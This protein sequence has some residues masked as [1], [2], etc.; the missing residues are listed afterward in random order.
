M[1][2]ERKI[3]VALQADAQKAFLPDD[4]LDRIEANCGATEGRI[5]TTAWL[6]RRWVQVATAALV[7]LPLAGFT[8]KQVWKVPAKPVTEQQ[9]IQHRPVKKVPLQ[10]LSASVGF[11]VKLPGYLPDGMT[12]FASVLAGDS[13]KPDA[14]LRVVSVSW[15]KDGVGVITLQEWKGDTISAFPP[16]DVIGTVLD[17]EPWHK[18]L[19][20][21]DTDVNGNPGS[22]LSYLLSGSNMNRIYWNDNGINYAV[23]AGAKISVSEL[24][25]VARSL[26]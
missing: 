24:L 11:P 20:R 14:Q 23:S 13:S 17:T 6:K 4:L 19:K 16:G 9:V 8:T 2:D 5:A 7:L 1:I 10:D 12:Q 21:T 26:K 18:T 3:T 25:K 22:V 15:A